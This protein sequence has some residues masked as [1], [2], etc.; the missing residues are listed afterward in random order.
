ML[1]Q[2]RPYDRVIFPKRVCTAQCCK[3]PQ[4]PG[5]IL[6]VCEHDSNTTH[7]VRRK[8]K[9][10]DWEL[11]P[12]PLPN[13]IL[14]KNH[15]AR[16]SGHIKWMFGFLYYRHGKDKLSGESSATLSLPSLFG[17]YRPAH[18]HD[19]RTRSC[20]WFDIHSTRYK[21]STLQLVQGIKKLN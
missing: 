12:G 11:N 4:A 8:K 1:I 16:P 20:Q 2:V 9:G 7:R 13:F 19:R 6:L 15:T 18:R 14:R 21:Y 3:Q 10:P 17:N 5:L